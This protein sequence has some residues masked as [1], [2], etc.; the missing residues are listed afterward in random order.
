MQFWN[1]F[2][3]KLLKNYLRKWYEFS[4]KMDRSKN[5]V[6]NQRFYLKIFTKI[7]FAIRILI[8]LLPQT[9]YIQ[10][11]EFH[12]FTEPLARKIFNVKTLIVWEFHQDHLLRS[13][14]FPQIFCGLVFKLINYFHSQ[15]P[16]SISSYG[17]L[18]VPRLIM[19]RYDC[20]SYQD[21]IQKFIH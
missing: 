20:K 15:D 4:T 7:L 19:V 18:I 16:S 11:D 6:K 10:P 12:Q 8:V 5:C 17:I 13:M 9:G 2:F 1:L 14:V 3:F 21:E